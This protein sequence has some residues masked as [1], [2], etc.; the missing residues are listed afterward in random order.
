MNE[1]IDSLKIKRLA[2]LP[3]LISGFYNTSS[4]VSSS[5][6]AGEINQPSQC[7]RVGVVLTSE[8]KGIKNGTSLCKHGNILIDAGQKIRVICLNTKKVLW[9]NSG[10]QKVSEICPSKSFRPNFCPPNNTCARKVLARFPL[11]VPLS[12]VSQTNRPIW[13]WDEISGVEKYQIR[14]IPVG[15]KLL[16]NTIVYSKEYQLPDNLSGLNRGEYYRI[17]LSAYD[18]NG[19]KKSE[20]NYSLYILSDDQIASLN[21]AK[22]QINSFEISQEEKVLYI[23]TLYNNL[24]LLGE[25]ISFL[26]TQST[27]LK[28]PQILTTLGDRYLQARRIVDA[29]RAYTEAISIARD[30]NHIGIIRNRLD[31]VRKIKEVLQSQL[32]IKIKFAQK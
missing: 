3:L 26:E 10:E 24:S 13:R 15:K 2:F 16:I 7:V 20:G 8:D 32:P 4:V 17:I 25:S 28:S 9:L 23:D 6:Y 29:E 18:K 30:N 22:S 14:I 12:G 1:R 27:V 21:Q 19:D 31:E 5:S 11:R